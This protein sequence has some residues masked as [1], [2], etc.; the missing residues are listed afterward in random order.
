[1]SG[2]PAEAAADK[3]R[4]E[5]FDEFLAEWEAEHGAITGEELAAARRRLG[6]SAT[7]AA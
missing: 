3:L 2:W 6:L 1:V 4:R 5:A 7:S